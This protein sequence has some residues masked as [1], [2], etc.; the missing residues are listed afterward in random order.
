MRVPV[1]GVMEYCDTSAWLKSV[2]N[3]QL[4]SPRIVIEVGLKPV[5][6]VGGVSA[7]RVPD[8]GLI[9]SAETVLEKIPTT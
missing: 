4:S 6:T 7:D 1:A 8:A 9:F 5:A 2:T 3:I